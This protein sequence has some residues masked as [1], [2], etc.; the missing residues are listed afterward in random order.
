M[1]PLT[2]LIR[3]Y[4]TTISQDLHMM[5]KSRLGNVEFF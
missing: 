1:V 3:S 5:G 2:F 4:Q